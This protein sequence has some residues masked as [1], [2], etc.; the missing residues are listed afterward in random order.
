[1]Y[2]PRPLKFPGSSLP[3]NQTIQPVLFAQN[4]NPENKS[5]GNVNALQVI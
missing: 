2:K 3:L 5:S 4:S 1:M